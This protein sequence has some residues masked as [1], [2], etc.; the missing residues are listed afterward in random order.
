MDFIKLILCWKVLFDTLAIAKAPS[1]SHIFDV[2][3]LQQWNIVYDSI[4]FSI[5]SDV[6]QWNTFILDSLSV[7]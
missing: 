5:N 2:T 6:E 4:Y 7:K 1:P 3:Q